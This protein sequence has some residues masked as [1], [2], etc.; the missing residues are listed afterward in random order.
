MAMMGEWGED[1]DVMT[2]HRKKEGRKERAKRASERGGCGE[3]S[4]E[5]SKRRDELSLLSWGQSRSF[6]VCEV[7]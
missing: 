6:A 5:R 2:N 3:S 4:R 7:F 1:D